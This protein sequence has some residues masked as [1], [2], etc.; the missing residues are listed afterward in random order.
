MHEEANNKTEDNV[1]VVPDYDDWIDSYVHNMRE[2]GFATL[3]RLQSAEVTFGEVF[4]LLGM[5]AF[6]D[7]R[8]TNH[9]DTLLSTLEKKRQSALQEIPHLEQIDVELLQTFVRLREGFRDRM[10]GESDG[11]KF[12]NFIERM[13]SGSPDDSVHKVM[14]AFAALRAEFFESKEKER[15]LADNGFDSADSALMAIM[16]L[17]PSLERMKIL[18][19]NMHVIEGGSC[20]D[21]NVE[22]LHRAYYLEGSDCDFVLSVSNELDAKMSL[23]REN[24]LVVNGDRF[25]ELPTEVKL[26]SV[27]DPRYGVGKT[28]RFKPKQHALRNDELKKLRSTMRDDLKEWKGLLQNI[29]GFSNLL[30]ILPQR[31][32]VTL[33]Q[34]V[35]SVLE[36]TLNPTDDE[37]DSKVE[38]HLYTIYTILVYFDDTIDHQSVL[39]LSLS[40]WIPGDGKHSG[41][42]LVDAYVAGKLVNSVIRKENILESRILPKPDVIWDTATKL[43]GERSQGKVTLL[44]VQVADQLFTSL[45]M[46]NHH[47]LHR[48]PHL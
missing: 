41:K 31:Q 20:I 15:L 47:T 34:L 5:E 19:G 1:L 26:V 24:V 22:V 44:N 3:Q 40:S 33:L 6:C 14:N 45:L 29:G 11:G 16:S 30:T 21:T 48:A 17:R 10:A 12:A 25:R 27:G 36:L 2:G 42:S 8:T 18:V 28:W 7:E 43:L 37:T 32:V 13:L 35:R 23:V 4:N 39:S 46:F 9:N 38:E